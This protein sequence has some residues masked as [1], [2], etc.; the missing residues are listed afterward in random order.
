MRIIIGFLIF[1]FGAFMTIKAEGFYRTIGPV[2]WAEK[3]LGL[4][5]GSRLFYKLFGIL[6]SF[7][8]L[9]IMAGLIQGFIL[10]IARPI[11]PALR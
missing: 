4:E 3:Y 7:I 11:F 5:G 9:L 8:G 10:A 1:A 6:M 2:A